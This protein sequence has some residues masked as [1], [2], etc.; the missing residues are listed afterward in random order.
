MTYN[1]EIKGYVHSIET[2]GM[3]DGPGVRYVIFLSG[4]PL[5]CKYCHNPDTWKANHGNFMSV[6]ELI[7]DIKK[8]RSYMKFSGGGVTI[9]GG[10]P[11]VQA[12]FLTELLK[13]CKANGF[14]TAVDTSGYTTADRAEQALQYADLLLLDIKSF[15]PTTYKNLTGVEL[16]KTLE[17]LK[18]AERLQVVT[19][20]RFVLLP[21]YT[22]NMEDMHKMADFLRLLENV[23]KVDVLPF[24]KMGEYKWQEIGEV[25]ELAAVEPPSLEELRLARSVLEM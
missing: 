2:A 13:A 4:C 20:V 22:D 7:A 9:T 17:T 12:E 11:F 8:Y 5:R 23:Q 15:N 6:G 24:H 14:H 25:Y 18:I 19:W 10:E 21:G 3:V 16:D 1:S